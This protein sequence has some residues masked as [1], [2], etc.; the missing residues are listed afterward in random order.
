MRTAPSTFPNFVQKD[1][2]SPSYAIWKMV[3]FYW[4]V[5]EEVRPERHVVL[6]LT[7]PALGVSHTCA[8]MWGHL[9]PR[10]TPLVLGQTGAP[11]DVG[12]GCPYPRCEPASTPTWGHLAPK[13]FALALGLNRASCGVGASMPRAYG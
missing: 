5:S 10:L 8:P 1:H 7:C 9:V 13:L 11:H 2:S 12:A 4:D 3:R 6:G